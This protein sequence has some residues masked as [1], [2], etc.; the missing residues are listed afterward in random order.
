[1][2]KYNTKYLVIQNICLLIP[3]ILYGIYKNGYLIKQK[4]LI[5]TFYIFKPLYLIVISIIIKILIDLIK[6]KKINIDYNLVYVILIPMIM[7][8]NINILLYT[9]CFIILYI[10]SNILEKYIKFNKVCF[11]YLVIILINFIF[12]EYTFQSI[13]E[14]NYTYNFN[15]ID[16]LM[17]RSIGG[18][19]STSIL[20]S[21]LA[22]IILLNNYYYKLDIP[23]IINITYLSLTII[24]FIFTNNNTYLINNDLIFGSI[25]IS[26]LP[27]F[28][29]YKRNVQILYSII[30]GIIS[31]IL[32]ITFNSIISIYLATFIISLLNNIII[33][34]K[35]TKHPIDIK[36]HL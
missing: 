33:R 12:N 17:G 3:L 6:D 25:F 30:I 31:F 8:Y 27:E 2:K 23:F 4:G 29:P 7:P 18:I 34:Q 21:L 36:K 24:Y 9:I 35:K 22:Y 32:S 28:S 10:L 16:L 19:S 11:I 15:F 26:S 5:N 14:Q 1:M 13:L 20:F